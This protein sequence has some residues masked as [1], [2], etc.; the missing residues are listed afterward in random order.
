MLYTVARLCIVAAILVSSA[1]AFT[2]APGAKLSQHQQLHTGVRLATVQ[3]MAEDEVAA[4]APAA[5]CG[6]DEPEGVVVPTGSGSVLMNDVRVTGTTLRGM[7][8]ADA[9]GNRV[10]TGSLLGA[11]DSRAVVVFLRHLG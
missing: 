11:V 3:L 10:Q 7:E 9:S 1:G 8:L 5:D 6:C 4:V 2:V